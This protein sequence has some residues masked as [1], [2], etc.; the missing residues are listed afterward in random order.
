MEVL[1]QVWCAPL[2]LSMPPSLKQ[3]VVLIRSHTQTFIVKC[4]TRSLAHHLPAPP[5]HV[6]GLSARYSLEVHLHPCQ[7]HNIEPDS[8]VSPCLPIPSVDDS[9]ALVSWFQAEEQIQRLPILHIPMA[10]LTLPG[11]RHYPDPRIQSCIPSI[12]VLLHR[13]RYIDQTTHLSTPDM[14]PSTHEIQ[15]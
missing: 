4:H 6:S 12:H 9:T 7:K 5:S 3:V 11:E 8:P 14:L 15:I 2:P 13:D 10:T 1:R